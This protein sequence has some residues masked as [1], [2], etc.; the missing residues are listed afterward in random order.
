VIDP[1]SGEKLGPGQVGEICVQTA[2]MTKGY[3]NRPDVRLV[4]DIV[5]CKYVVTFVLCG[6]SYLN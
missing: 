4:K 5:G 6:I 3:L 2:W 1:E